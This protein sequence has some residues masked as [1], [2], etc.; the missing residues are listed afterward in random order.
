MKICKIG[1]FK[2]LILKNSVIS[3]RETGIGPS[4]R[5]HLNTSLSLTT[6]VSDLVG[7][8]ITSY[9]YLHSSLKFCS[10]GS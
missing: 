6:L 8:I 4:A 9:R 7:S 10:W 3:W 1:I 2:Q 5:L